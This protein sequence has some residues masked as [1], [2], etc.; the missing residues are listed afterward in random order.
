MAKKQTRS[1]TTIQSESLEGAIMEHSTQDTVEQTIFS[2]IHK[3]C[4]SLAGEAPICNGELF[5]DFG[6]TSNT[7]ASQA[8]LDGMYVPPPNSDTVTRDLFAEIAAIQSTVPTNSVSFVITPEQCKQYW[9]V[10]NEETASSESGIQFGH[11]IVDCSSDIISHY[12]A[13]CMTV[14]LAHAI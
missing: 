13:T 4:Y 3:K 8:V 2:E 1:A 9:Q 14:T 10:I 7:L 6:Y 11:Y 12:H 5:Q